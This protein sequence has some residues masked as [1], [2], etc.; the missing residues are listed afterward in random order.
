MPSG[1]W[2]NG[3]TNFG[4][5][6]C[7]SC[8]IAECQAQCDGISGCVGFDSQVPL[9]SST[10]TGTCWLKSSL[11]VASTDYR[12]TTTDRTTWFNEGR[13]TDYTTGCTSPV[14]PPPP[15]A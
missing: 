3:G 5:D 10:S 9:S 6:V 2:E 7:S 4:N 8:T 14:S 1:Y 12:S 15:P 13:N 11:S